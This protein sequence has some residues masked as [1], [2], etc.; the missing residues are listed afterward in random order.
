MNLF[1]GYVPTK[2]KKCLTTF[3]NKTSDQLSTYEEVKHLPEFAGILND[4]V[5]LID[6]DDTEE[7]EILFKIIDD[8]QVRCRIYQTSRGM[9]FL[10]K[11]TTVE[12]CKT[13]TKLACGLTADI[14]LG[15]R[16]SYSILK[17]NNKEREIIYDKFDD[18]E[19]QELPKWL[20]PVKSKIDFTNMSNGDGRSQSLFNYILTLQS[21]RF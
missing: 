4:E 11:K 5:I 6:I 13:H 10:F 1:K 19:Y 17:F 21:L 12:T 16:N 18:E 3:K 7:A 9:H 20:L 14:K 8:L 15:S 2:N